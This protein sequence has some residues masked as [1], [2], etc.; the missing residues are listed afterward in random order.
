MVFIIF[1]SF[2]LLFCSFLY[3]YINKK[4]LPQKWDELYS[5]FHP[6]Y[7]VQ[8]SA[9]L[10]TILSNITKATRISFHLQTLS[11]CA[12]NAS[13][14]KYLL[15]F[16][17]LTRRWFSAALEQETFQPMS[18]LLFEQITAY[19]SFSLSLFVLILYGN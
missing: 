15:L 10:V 11:L 2:K 5:R 6:N 14:R 17:Y 8:L 3:F 18:F 19:S 12:V 4:L 16:Q 1:S 13:K 9:L 7:S